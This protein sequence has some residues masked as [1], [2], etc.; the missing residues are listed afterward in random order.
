MKCL[1]CCPSLPCGGATPS[2]APSQTK[3]RDW[4]GRQLA[5]EFMATSLF[6]WAGTGAAVASDSWTEEGALDPA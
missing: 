5:A 1:S 2:S 3:A 6:V 4:T